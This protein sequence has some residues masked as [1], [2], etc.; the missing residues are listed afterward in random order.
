MLVAWMVYLLSF[1]HSCV[2]SLSNKITC[3]Q[4]EYA[5]N[6]QSP[7]YVATATWAVI[8]V[9]MKMGRTNQGSSEL[10]H[11]AK[12]LIW[13]KNV[14]LQ[15]NTATYKTRFKPEWLTYATDGFVESIEKYILSQNELIYCNLECY[16]K[17]SYRQKN[18][19]IPH[20][21]Y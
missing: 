6:T 8:N 7:G 20:I 13:N 18:W 17:F 19:T 1:Q 11:I 9:L 12:T 4:A 5:Y 10:C 21:A 15:C 3:Y 2:T 14:P 16:I